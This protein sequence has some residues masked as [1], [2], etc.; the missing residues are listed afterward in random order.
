MRSRL[1]PASCI[2]E[3]SLLLPP[4]SCRSVGVTSI[5]RSIIGF[6]SRQ[7]FETAFGPLARLQYLDEEHLRSIRAAKRFQMESESLT[8]TNLMSFSELRPT[9]DHDHG[10]GQFLVGRHL[11][12]GMGYSLKAT[13]KSAAVARGQQT[14]ILAEKKIVE[15]LT[16]HS[17]FVPLV[18][19][20]FT[21]NGYLLSVYKV[22][23]TEAVV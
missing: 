9:L 15:L 17:E 20:T 1:G 16:K 3:A 10:L 4:G 5:S 7:N 21:S 13:S 12:T 11:V 6:M 22:P 8:Q 19:S 2:G 18:L 14:A 23:A